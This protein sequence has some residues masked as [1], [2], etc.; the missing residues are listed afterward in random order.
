MR[1]LPE[2]KEQYKGCWPSIHVHMGIDS[3][4][5]SGK[6][7]ACPLCG[8]GR[9]RFRYANQGGMGNYYCNQC[10]HGD[11]VQL[12]MRYLNMNFK[13][14]AHEIRSIKGDI[15]MEAVQIVDNTHKNQAR[16]DKIRSG[17]KRITPESIAGRYLANC[18]ITVFPE[19]SCCYHPSLTYWVVDSNTGKPVSLGEY[20]AIVS[21]FRDNDGKES[22][23]HLTFIGQDGKKLN[24]E[25]EGELVPAKKILPP[26]IPLTGTAIKLF[27]A[28]DTVCIAEGLCSDLS[29]YQDCGLPVWIAGNCG[30]MAKLDLPESIKH[31]YIYED[32]DKSFSGRLA[33]ST[34]ASRLAIKGGRETIKIISLVDTHQ[35]IVSQESFDF[36][37][38][39][40]VN[41]SH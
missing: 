36:N 1:A 40:I 2:L 21:V 11:G 15:K 27:D 26:V 17:L 34:L 31:I 38:Y 4:F 23:F 20:P 32:A 13:E 37:D 30:N 28:T 24:I 7:Q 8:E 9:N 12:V 29:A 41:A 18:G 6:H 25:H 14:A 5:L 16:L 3:R 33:A 19:K 10:G 39:L 35:V 22:T